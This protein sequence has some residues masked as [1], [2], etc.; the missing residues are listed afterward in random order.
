VR[1][2]KWVMRKRC[3]R[4]REGRDLGGGMSVWMKV[5]KEGVLVY[6]MEVVMDMF[7]RASHSP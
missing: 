4:I 5:C 1:G 3:L 7:G 2:D 6:M